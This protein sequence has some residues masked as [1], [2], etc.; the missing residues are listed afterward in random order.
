LIEDYGDDDWL[1]R[2]LAEF[3][4]AINLGTVPSATIADG[5]AA[6]RC[7]L[8]AAKSVTTGARVAVVA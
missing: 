2:E 3:A 4:V 7:A 8:A 5:R 1:S 6:L